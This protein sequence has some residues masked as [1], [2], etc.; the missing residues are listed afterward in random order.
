MA[1]RTRTMMARRT[2]MARRRNRRVKRRTR[3]D[4]QQGGGPVKQTKVDY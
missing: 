4:G 3:R 2:R 1:T